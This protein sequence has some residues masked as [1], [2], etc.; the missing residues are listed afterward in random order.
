MF[1]YAILLEHL[2]YKILG[3]LLY[4][5]ESTWQGA[6][7]DYYNRCICGEIRKISEYPI[8]SGAVYLSSKALWVK[9]PSSR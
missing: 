4:S 5:S 6:S 8:L 9:G 3:Y 1:A 7:E 2:V